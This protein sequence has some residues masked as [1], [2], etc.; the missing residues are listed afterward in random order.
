MPEHIKVGP[1]VKT[2]DWLPQND[3]LGHKKLK[4][5][6]SHMGANGAYEAAYHGVPIV[7]ACI[8]GDNFDNAQRF[9]HKAKM[10]KIIDVYNANSS[11]WQSTIEELIYNPRYDI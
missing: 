1:N 6:V 3:L 7:A 5:F 4:A 8:W 10:G 2:L 11:E 9:V